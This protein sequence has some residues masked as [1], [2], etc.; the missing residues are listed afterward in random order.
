MAYACFDCRVSFKKPRLFEIDITKLNYPCPNCGKRLNYMGRSFQPPRRNA[1]RQWRIVAQLHTHGY[2]FES[3]ANDPLPRTQ[4]ELEELLKNPRDSQNL[5]DAARTRL[6]REARA[7][8]IGA[9]GK[10]DASR[11]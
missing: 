1:T 7:R 4:R 9:T 2:R 8:K 11:M 6:A 5:T 3:L 10:R